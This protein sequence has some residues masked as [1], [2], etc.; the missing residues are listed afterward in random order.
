[1]TSNRL[2]TCTFVGSDS[3]N[4]P[5]FVSADG[6]FFVARETADLIADLLESDP[7]SLL[8]FCEESGYSRD[9]FDL[10]QMYAIPECWVL[11]VEVSD[12]DLASEAWRIMAASVE[13]QRLALEAMPSGAPGSAE[14]V[15]IDEAMMSLRIAYV[16]AEGALVKW[17]KLLSA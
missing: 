16:M 10:P 11:F 1:M 6:H 12:V 13:A 3:P 4:F 15:A 14:R 5:T 9:N 17:R 7:D 2:T 8:E